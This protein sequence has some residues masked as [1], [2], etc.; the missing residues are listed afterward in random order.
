MITSYYVGVGDNHGLLGREHI[1]TSHRDRESD[2]L[3]TASVY[4]VLIRNDEL[5][6]TLTLF[7][8]PLKH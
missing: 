5:S 8:R 4:L 1:P 3:A 2:L 7:S 6:I